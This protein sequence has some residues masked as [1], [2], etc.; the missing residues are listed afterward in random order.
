LI[1]NDCQENNEALKSLIREELLGYSPGRKTQSR[2]VTDDL[3]APNVFKFRQVSYGSDVDG[4]GCGTAG[5]LAPPPH[6]RAS[7]TAASPRA[8][9]AERHCNE[10]GN[11]YVRK[12]KKTPYKVLDAPGL[13]D[14]FYLNLIDWSQRNVLA[15]GLGS[16]VYL[17]S[18]TTAK[19][20]S[21]C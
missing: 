2:E 15:V 16:R 17:W 11:C 20:E 21:I 3:C 13:K 7:L 14:D 6:A 18:A 4:A 1:P 5:A 8:A 12:I 9:I 10:P 19:V